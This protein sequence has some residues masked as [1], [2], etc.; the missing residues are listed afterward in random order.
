MRR[1]R[2]LAAL[3]AAV[4]LLA[5]GVTVANAAHVEVRGG[6]LAV[7][8]AGPPCEGS[9]ALTAPVPGS[10]AQVVAAVPAGCAGR[11]LRV[12]LPTTHGVRQGA[13]VVPEASGGAP[14]AT[15]V[16]TTVVLDGPFQGTA[17][18][19]P[20]ATVGGW[21]LPVTWSPAVTPGVITATCRTYAANGSPAPDRPCAATVRL[22]TARSE[23]YDLALTV[24]DTRETVG[25]SANNPVRWEVTIDLSGAPFR[26][27]GVRSSGLLAVSSCAELPLL[28]VRGVT[29]WG[30]HHELRRGTVRAD[31]WLQG[32]AQRGSQEILVCP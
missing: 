17:A 4:G 30:D 32:H 21:S 26:P 7:L 13:V 29:G 19:Q 25:T 8:A 1:A 12:A 15:T 31:L 27:L 16:T 23:G 18:V 11:I 9:V 5:L 20:A 22:G 2:P 10:G 3:L 28:T 24:R 6:A 14:A